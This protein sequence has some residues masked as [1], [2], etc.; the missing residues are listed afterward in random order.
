[1]GKAL[2]KLNVPVLL[3]MSL[4]LSACE[5]EAPGPQAL[6]G[7]VERDGLAL[8]LARLETG[9]EQAEDLSAV[10]KLQKA[11]GY[12]LDK[13]M[14]TDL[15]EFFADDAVANYP[16]GVFIGKDCIR[17][18]LYLNVGGVQMGEVGLGDGRLYNHMNI[19]PVVHLR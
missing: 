17:R 18:H 7:E 10:K 6:A 11:Y 8:R 9:I 4:L 2:S 5:G 1:M 3:G 15:A 12:Y 13:G 19:Q 16:A 14:W